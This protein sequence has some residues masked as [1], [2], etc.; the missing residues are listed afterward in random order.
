MSVMN[1]SYISQMVNVIIIPILINYVEND[2][3]DGP[4]GLAG[5]AHDFQLT[6]F[7]FMTLFNLINV[8]HRFIQ[9]LKCFKC[10]RRLVIRYLCRVTGDFD[11]Y[12]EMKDALVFLYDP[13]LVPVAGLYVYITTIIGQAFFFCHLEPAVIFYLII[14]LLLFHNENR[15]LILRMCKIT[16]LLDISVFET[17][18][19]FALNIPLLY[20]VASIV[21]LKIRGDA[22]NFSYYVPSML[23]ILVWFLSIQSPFDFHGRLVNCLIKTFR[24]LKNNNS[25]SE[26]K[27]KDDASTYN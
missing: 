11:S 14:N 16:D 17:V 23:C 20:G 1:K 22:S 15:Y 18:V 19:G 5:Q 8:P 25:E 4:T 7:I 3:L 10:L 9:F 26:K 2:N 24:S 21:F 27:S 12:S 13:P 6:S